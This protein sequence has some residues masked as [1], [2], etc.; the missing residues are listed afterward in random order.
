MEP[1]N[2]QSVEL[3]NKPN[4]AEGRAS[5]AGTEFSKYSMYSGWNT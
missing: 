4:E 1:D 2:R 3:D 5:L